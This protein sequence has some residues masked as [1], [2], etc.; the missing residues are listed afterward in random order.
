MAGPYTLGLLS[1]IAAVLLPIVLGYQA[2]TYW[3]FR[4][5]ITATPVSA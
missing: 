2:W 4:K 3:V 1:V 5:R